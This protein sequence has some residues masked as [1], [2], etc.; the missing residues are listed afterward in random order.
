MLTV[1]RIRRSEIT[2]K[3][4]LL[5]RQSEKENGKSQLCHGLCVNGLNENVQRLLDRQEHGEG[6]V[7][8]NAWEHVCS[9]IEKRGI[10]VHYD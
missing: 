9:C 3:V 10:W 1:A 4:V 7:G 6:V 8:E 5:F 2:N